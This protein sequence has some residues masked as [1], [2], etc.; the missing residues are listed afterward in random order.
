MSDHKIRLEALQKKIEDKRIEKAKLEQR[1][2]QLQEENTKL[3]KEL[4]DLG[5]NTI[6]ELK[7]EI[8]KLEKEIEEGIASAEKAL[9]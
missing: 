5:I 7:I 8:T 3:M 6:E 1:K 4:F 2:E 9:N